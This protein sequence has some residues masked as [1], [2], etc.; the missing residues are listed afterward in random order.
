MQYMAAWLNGNGA[1][2][3]YN[4]MEDAAT[5]EISRSQV[6]QWVHH[7]A[8]LNDGRKIT[9][10][11]VDHVIAEESAKLNGR[12]GISQAAGLFAEMI[13]N[14]QF[15]EFLTLVGYDHID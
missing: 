15:T 7:G 9:P 6:W 5:A 8:S 2:P 13:H 14:R 10:E 12:P 11:L 4:L 3:I 1:V